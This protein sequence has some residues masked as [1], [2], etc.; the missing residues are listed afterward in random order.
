MVGNGKYCDAC[1]TRGASVGNGSY[2]GYKPGKPDIR[3]QELVWEQ[4][5]KEEAQETAALDGELLANGWRFCPEQDRWVRSED[6]EDIL[7]MDHRVGVAA[8]EEG[9]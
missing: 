5:L 9:E 4:A 6:A 2:N 7:R 1:R 3:W 8:W